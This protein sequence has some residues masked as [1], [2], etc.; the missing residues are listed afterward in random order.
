MKVADQPMNPNVGDHVWDIMCDTQCLELCFGDVG[1]RN[2]R[3]K[4]MLW[5]CDCAENAKLNWWR[6]TGF[7]IF[8][9]QKPGKTS[10]Q[11]DDS[12]IKADIQQ[13]MK[14]CECQDAD[15]SAY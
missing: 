11:L 13:C 12:C 9:G 6:H 2:M 14:G 5:R 8:L 15:M 10:V 3:R 7:L 4:L 1:L